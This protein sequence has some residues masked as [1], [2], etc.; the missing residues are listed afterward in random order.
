MLVKILS[1]LP[2]VERQ[3][4]DRQDGQVKV[5]KVKGYIVHNGE[6][7]LYVEAVQEMA[8][9][10]EKTPIQPN[11][12]AFMSLTSVARKYQSNGTERYSNEFQVKSFF[13]I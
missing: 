12:C 13:M 6:G 8:E 10:M 4:T 1:I 5:F 2:M 9:L 7:T 11:D 3:Y